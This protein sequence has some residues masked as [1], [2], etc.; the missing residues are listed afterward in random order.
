MSQAMDEQQMTGVIHDAASLGSVRT[1]HFSGGEP[2]LLPKQLMSGI[3][4]ATRLGMRTA[5]VTSAFFAKSPWRAMKMLEPVVAAGLSEISVSYDDMHAIFVSPGHLINVIECA[6]A[7]SLKAFVSVTVEPGSRIDG[8]FVRQLL[9]ISPDE[10]GVRVFEVGIN[11][12]GR[13]ADHVDELVLSKRAASALVYH[14]PCRTV[15]RTIQ[16]TVDGRVLPCCGVLPHCD[17]MTIGNAFKPRGL[18]EAVEAA[19][20]SPIW[21]VI[22]IKGPVQMVAEAMDGPTAAINK[23]EFDGIC[24][25]CDRLF[26]DPVLLTRVR[27]RAARTPPNQFISEDGDE[28][29]DSLGVSP[30][31]VRSC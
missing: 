14:G 16:V 18:L 20:K 3:S 28:V 5:V 21:R 19:S 22:A 4:L 10:P 7:L 27:Q 2:F 8:A 26:N 25:A 11:T 24:S 17:T 9:N 23:C 6:R 13:A 31:P 15:L 1:I 30:K 29:V 12:T